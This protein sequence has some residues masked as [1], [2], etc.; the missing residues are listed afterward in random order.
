M[1]SGSPPSM[2]AN[3]S[4]PVPRSRFNAS[5]FPIYPLTPMDPDPNAFVITF[6]RIHRSSANSYR[7]AYYLWWAI[8]IVFVGFV[9]SH[10]LHIRASWLGAWFSRW[11]LR[12]R[13]WRK[14]AHERFKKRN[15][16]THRQPTIMASNAQL[17]TISFL[18]GAVIL[19]CFAGPDYI[20]PNASFSQFWPRD[21]PPSPSEISQFAPRY[22]I[23]KAWWTVGNRTGII[24]FALLPLVVLFALKA[25]P[26][27]LLSMPWTLNLHFDKLVRLHRWTGLLAWVVC[28]IHAGAWT[29]QV[30]TETRSGDRQTGRSL[31]VCLLPLFYVQVADLDAQYYAFLYPNFRYAL[32]SYICMTVLMIMSLPF[33]RKRYYEQFFFAHIILVPLFIIFAALHFPGIAYWCWI[34]LGLWGA[35]RAIRLGRFL[36]VNGY[37]LRSI[38]LGV[39]RVPDYK[40]SHDWDKD[41]PWLSRKPSTRN[42]ESFIA[43][44]E[45]HPL[46]LSDI[47]RIRDPQSIP[48]GFAKAELL[49]GRTMR[50][51]VMTHRGFRW[52]PGQHAHLRVPS[53]SMWTTHP[54]TI[55]SVCQ[56][57]TFGSDGT[58]DAVTFIIRAKSGFTKRLWNEISRL[59]LMYPG[60]P[61]NPEVSGPSP[62]VLLRAQ[63]DG[64]MG[65]VS[66][67][68]WDEFSTVV[69]IC[70]GSGVSFGVAILQHLCFSLAAMKKGGG[71]P[72]KV[73]RIRF[74]WLIRE[75]GESFLLYYLYER[76]IERCSAYAMGRTRDIRMPQDAI[77][78]LYICYYQNR[79]PRL[80][81]GKEARFDCFSCQHSSVRP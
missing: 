44:M 47:P 41:K 58:F 77:Q 8:F 53:I 48:T 6:M 73:D 78:I 65:S 66:R 46:G 34:A 7:Y 79:H 42:R 36:Y 22:T 20:S 81:P 18:T 71:I 3:E 39:A 43:Y 68:R 1:A 76:L 38:N 49:P 17:L 35:D 70:G 23:A 32:T 29:I 74:I 62:P 54:F 12:R 11:S 10:Q 80:E 9:L 61:F 31:W 40:A 52:A 28:T 64:P 37:I 24:T 63:I 72:Y 69:I 57:D 33:V 55:A 21:P 19:A 45:H 59:M 16:K 15:P 30:S 13:T 26:T 56:A 2:D 75:Y 67:V 5:Q 4:Q 51:Q 14:Q 27:A 50:I 25:P 60:A